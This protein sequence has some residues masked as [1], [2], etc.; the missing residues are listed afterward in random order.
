MNEVL[1]A[2]NKNIKRS[3]ENNKKLYNI[4]FNS[5]SFGRRWNMKVEKIS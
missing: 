2:R 3:Q 4:C 1:S 5:F